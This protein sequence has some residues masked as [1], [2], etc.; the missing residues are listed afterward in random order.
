MTELLTPWTAKHVKR[1]PVM[2]ID[3][4]FSDPDTI[5]KW[6]LSLEYKPSPGGKWPG[7]RTIPLA[8][9][10]LKFQNEVIRKIFSLY[11]GNEADKVSYDYP[12]TNFFF[13]IIPPYDKDNPDAKVNHGWI[14][15]DGLDKEN[16]MAGVIYLTPNISLECG[17]SIYELKDGEAYHDKIQVDMIDSKQST[18][19]EL[20]NNKK[21]ENRV[22]KWNNKFEETIR[23]NNIYNRMISYD[24]HYYHAANSYYTPKDAA[25]R[26]IL[27]YFMQNL[28]G[29]I[30]PATRVFKDN[31]TKIIEDATA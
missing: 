15:K 31:A 24:A 4:F 16:M 5:R 10:N 26:L 7:K 17:T 14:H 3:N 1:F 9:I 2:C 30:L 22:T 28:K 13:Q 23:V 21:I 11:F 6:A 8:D 19:R 27:V 20:Q 29:V 25:D 18:Y 12:K